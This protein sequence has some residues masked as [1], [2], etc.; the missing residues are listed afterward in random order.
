MQ[1]DADDM[2]NFIK[3]DP[4]TLISEGKQL[5]KTMKSHLKLQ[6]ELKSVL[7]K[8]ELQLQGFEVDHVLGADSFLKKFIKLYKENP[9]LKNHLAVCLLQVAVAKMSGD[10]NPLLPLKV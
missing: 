4:N 2:A 7:S 5:L 9:K 3:T 1:S 10:H 6:H 8:S